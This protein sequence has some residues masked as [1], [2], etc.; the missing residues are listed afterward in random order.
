MLDQ[1]G[2]TP[3]GV[4]HVFS[5]AWCEVG[6]PMKYFLFFILFFL[7]SCADRYRYPCQ[8]PNNWHKTEC[9]NKVCEIEGTCTKH[10]L[11]KNK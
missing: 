5:R 1:Q 8:D 4:F 10:V 2:S 3:Y 11:A 7:G 6:I 9:N